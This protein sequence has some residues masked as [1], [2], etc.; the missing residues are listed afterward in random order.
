MRGEAVPQRV[1]RDALVDLKSSHPASVRASRCKA[2]FW[3]TVDTR[4]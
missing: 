1:Q 4:A 2:R 3:S